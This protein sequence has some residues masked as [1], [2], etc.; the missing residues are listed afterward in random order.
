[1]ERL[2]NVIIVEDEESAAELL[3]GIIREFVDDIKICGI[4]TNV[5]DGY[6]L[7]QSN[8]PDLIFVD[9]QLKNEMIFDLLD[10]IEYKKYHIVFTTAYETY[11]FKA[12]KYEAFDYLLKPY[13]PKEVIK[14]IEKVRQTKKPD[15]NHDFRTLLKAIAPK[16]EKI[17]LHTMDG[18]SLCNQADVMYCQGDGAYCTVFI[19]NEGRLLV[20][21]SIGD[22]ED[23]LNQNNFIRVHTSHLININHVKKY[24]K[25]DG[26]SIMI[27]LYR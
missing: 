16:S 1:M 5:T 24:L 9:V 4:A 19:K 12:F 6:D 14:V 17:S 22:L 3:E 25:E 23:M 8:K 11:A 26:G 7:I 2:L 18:I 27:R 15:V 13:S 20:S 10:K 21:K